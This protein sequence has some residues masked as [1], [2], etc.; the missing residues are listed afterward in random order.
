[1]GSR[2]VR[3]VA[4]LALAALIF[5]GEW[6]LFSRPIGDAVQAWAYR[7]G[8]E[9]TVMRVWVAP[10]LI[11]LVVIVIYAALALWVASAV[12]GRLMARLGAGK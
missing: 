10:V 4:S 1:M 3:V 11:G 6:H 12:V 9:T 2:V 5:F 7:P 8:A